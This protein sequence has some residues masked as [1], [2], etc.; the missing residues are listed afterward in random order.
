[1]LFIPADAFPLPVA[2]AKP[3]ASE[4]TAWLCEGLACLPEM[5]DREELR[6]ALRLEK[7]PDPAAAATPR[8][9]QE[10]A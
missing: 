6:R 2:L 7:I 8:P 1:V 10:T 9:S 5:R 3:A 4:V